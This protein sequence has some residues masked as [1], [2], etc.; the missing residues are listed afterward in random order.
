MFE[1]DF[2]QNAKIIG[3]FEIKINDKKPY[4]R[5]NEI[6]SFI[7]NYVDRD[8]H[9]ESIIN[10]ENNTLHSRVIFD[11]KWSD[12]PKSTSNIT[13]EL[14]DIIRKQLRDINEGFIIRKI[15]Y[16]ELTQR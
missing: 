3:G 16:K 15:P 2:Y 6:R 7:G 8:F 10:E 13:N 14:A 11:P 12:L 5:L 4:D 1:L 9:T